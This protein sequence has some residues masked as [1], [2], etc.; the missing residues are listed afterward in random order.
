MD[1]PVYFVPVDFSPASYKAVEYAMMLIQLSGGRIVLFHVIDP[2]QIAESDNPIVVHR[3]INRLT[4]SANDKLESISE[5][6]RE[7][8][9]EV[10]CELTFGKPGVEISKFCKAHADHFAVISQRQMTSIFGGRGS[11]D[12]KLPLF[13]VP[14]S[15]RMKRPHN[16][17]LATDLKP[18]RANGFSRFLKLINKTCEEL[19][20]LYVTKKPV[21]N[22]REVAIRQRMAE[23]GK[24]IN[25]NTTFSYQQHGNIASGILDFSMDNG[26]DLLCTIKRRNGISRY[27]SKSI[28]NELANESALPMLVL[29]EC[30]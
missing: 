6:I 21:Y 17:L 9:L 5:M 4:S 10:T 13:I 16:V 11:V 7:S 27:L 25:I 30:E 1:K 8:G 12:I 28:S 23:V 29:N 26:I 15:A 2:D 14:E 3:S 24:L 18:I 22:G 20:L 19:M